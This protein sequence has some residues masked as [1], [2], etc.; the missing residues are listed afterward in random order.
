M[1]VGLHSNPHYPLRRHVDGKRR[2]RGEKSRAKSLTFTF[3]LIPAPIM[4]YTCRAAA[5]KTET[6]K[7]DTR[8]KKQILL[9]R[10]R[11]KMG[12]GEL[13]LEEWR[14]KVIRIPVTKQQLAALLHVLSNREELFPRG[15][16][17]GR[18]QP[19]LSWLTTC[20]RNSVVHCG[21]DTGNPRKLGF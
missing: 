6:P 3:L 16:W 4:V 11:K 15:S 5:P 17:E 7:T 19:P 21:Y 20:E 10:D 12:K 9:R 13:T 18:G 8:W 1:L 14:N 2:K